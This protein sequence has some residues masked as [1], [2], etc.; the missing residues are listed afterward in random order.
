MASAQ[1]ETPPSQR[2]LPGD[3]IDSLTHEFRFGNFEGQLTVGFYEGRDPAMIQM[4]ASKQPPV[5]NGLLSVLSDTATLAL[6]YG[7]PLE[8]MIRR[9]KGKSFE[10]SGLTRRPQISY[11]RSVVDYV[12]QY[13]GQVAQQPE[14]RR[15]TLAFSDQDDLSLSTH[16]VTVGQMWLYLTIGTENKSPRTVRQV[17]MDAGKEGG[18][19]DGLLK[20]VGET[21][22]LAL[23]YDVPLKEVVELWRGYGFPPDGFTQNPDIPHAKS[24]PDYVARFLE[25]RF[26]QQ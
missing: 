8:E 14:D 1:S 22:S 10:P 12:A 26:L 18:I 6:Q 24:I 5:V 17:S 9:W 13:L 25:L 4:S 3:T 23:R 11:A 20:T 15:A 21:A 16:K 2:R 7:V 19:I